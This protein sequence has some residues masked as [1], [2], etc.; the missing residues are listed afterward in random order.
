MYGM[1]RCGRLHVDLDLRYVAPLSRHLHLTCALSLSHG[2]DR[3][4]ASVACKLGSGGPARRAILSG[5]EPISPLTGRLAMSSV[6]NFLCGRAVHHT[7]SAS[8]H[9]CHR[10]RP[11]HGRHGGR[12]FHP[13]DPR[14]PR[15]S[16]TLEFFRIFGQTR[17]HV[18]HVCVRGSRPR[19]CRHYK[20]LEQWS[21]GWSWRYQTG[22]W[23]GL[24]VF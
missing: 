9:A 12:L 3:H 4:L 14:R 2:T 22:C 10:P 1:Y 17:K 15:C 23:L 20:W 19:K 8:H 5:Y 21:L 6:A 16:C 24:R 7:R 13:L 11:R 18:T